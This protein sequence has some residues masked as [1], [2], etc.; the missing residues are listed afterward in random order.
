MRWWERSIGGKKRGRI[1]ALL[2]RD[3]RTVEEIAQDL[4]VTSNAARAQL[5]LLEREGLVHTVGTRPQPGAGKPAAVYAMAEQAEASLSA[6]YAPVLVA[7]L[8]TLG[9]HLSSA[10]LD[11]VLRET[12]RR[13]AP[14]DVRK[15]SVDARV[16]GAAAALSAMGGELTVEKT[17]TGFQLRGYACPLAAAVRAHPHAC[18]A[19]EELVASYVGVPVRE[20]CDRTDGARC[21]FDV[22]TQSA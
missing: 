16:R 2:R 18:L 13:L 1:I 3:D 4:R 8:A 14:P 19:V 20:R 5:Q 21:R 10:A 15:S 17:A 6:A 22:N 9:E 12:G 11:E 7:L